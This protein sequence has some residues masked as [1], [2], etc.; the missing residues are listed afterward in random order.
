MKRH[1]NRH[2]RDLLLSSLTQIGP[3]QYRATSL[4]M[5]IEQATGPRFLPGKFI[6]EFM[7]RSGSKGIRTERLETV[8]G[9]M[10]WFIRSGRAWWLDE[11]A[12][13]GNDGQRQSM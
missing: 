9:M 11:Q 4:Q 7:D 13:P 10:A 3:R 6:V 2:E 12:M 1:I 8:I 5:Q